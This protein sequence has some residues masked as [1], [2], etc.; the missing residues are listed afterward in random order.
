MI[1]NWIWDKPKNPLYPFRKA[2]NCDPNTRPYS[3][4]I[5]WNIPLQCGKAITIHRSQCKTFQTVLLDLSRNNIFSPNM[6]YVALSRAKTLDGIYILSLS[7]DAFY[8]FP[9]IVEMYTILD[10]QMKREYAKLRPLLSGTRF[11]SMIPQL[12][13]NNNESTV[14]SVGKDFLTTL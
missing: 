10:E 3:G 11:E 8:V 5:F 2:I 12:D 6:A 1:A 13:T 7:R 4:I 14:V 9:E